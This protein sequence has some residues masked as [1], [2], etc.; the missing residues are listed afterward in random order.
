MKVFTC[1]FSKQILSLVYRFLFVLFILPLVSL[2][3]LSFFLSLFL[4][5]SIAERGD[6]DDDEDDVLLG[7]GEGDEGEEERSLR[8]LYILL[9]A[10]SLSV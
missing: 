7:R 8:N 3:C 10:G 5:K 1:R 2:L 9:F 4:S 6:H